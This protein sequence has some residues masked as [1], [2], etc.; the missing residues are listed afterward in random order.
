MR[1]ESKHLRKA[2]ATIFES[3]NDKNLKSGINAQYK[4]KLEYVDLGKESIHKQAMEISL[5]MKEMGYPDITLQ[6][7]GYIKPNSLDKFTF[8]YNVIISLL[9]SL[10]ETS[11]ITYLELGKNLN[12][13]KKFQ[14]EAINSLGNDKEINSNTNK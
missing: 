7:F 2:W 10:T 4:Y 13:D 8:E 11:L 3:I 1:V 12:K 5:I 6:K 14:K 9:T